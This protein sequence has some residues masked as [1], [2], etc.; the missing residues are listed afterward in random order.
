M[1][2]V[3]VANDSDVRQE[4]LPASGTTV[5]RYRILCFWLVLGCLAFALDDAIQPSIHRLGQQQTIN[6]IAEHW[7]MLAETGGIVLFILAML[8]YGN[9]HRNP[10]LLALLGVTVIGQACKHL[11]GRV[12]P[13]WTGDTT[14]FHGPLGVWGD[15]SHVPIDSLPSGHTMVA[16]AMASLLTARWSQAKWLWFA[17]AGGVGLSRTLVD[18]HFPSDVIFGGLLGTIIGQS[19]IAIASDANRNAGVAT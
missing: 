8:L 16:F 13:H 14:I 10:A 12:R 7:Q 5:F 2:V 9:G 19:A 6:S 3:P 4:P 17:L 15:G 18:V 11:I 1:D